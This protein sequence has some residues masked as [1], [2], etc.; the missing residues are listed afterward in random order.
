M[1]RLSFLVLASAFSTKVLAALVHPRNLDLPASPPGWKSIICLEDNRAFG[2]PLF[3]GAF[4]ADSALTIEKCI[5]FCDSQPV[6]YRYMGLTDGFECSCDNFFEYIFESVPGSCN[7]PCSGNPSEVGGCGGKA[8]L[9][10]LAS[11]YQR[12]NSTFV[13]PTM[14]S[15]VGLWNGLGCYNDSVSARALQVRVDAGQTTV[16]SCVAA[17]QTQGFSLAGV[18]FGRECWCGSQLQ[19]GSK[20]FGNSDGIQD[21]RLRQTPNAPFCNMA[22]QGNPSE[23]CGGPAL[24]NLYNFTGTYPIGASVVTTAGGWTSQGCYSDS[25]SSRTLERRVDVGSVTVESCVAACQSQSFTIAG[26]EYAQECWCGNEIKSPGVPISQ[27]ACHQVCIGDST[28][29]CGGPN[30]LQLYR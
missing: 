17:C 25:V 23:I 26:L 28:E 27:S 24:L 4:Y 15:S 9:Q 16:E 21:G 12:I 3:T 13:I 20:F 2:L 14:V 5:A 6:S 1:H 22:C 7:T 19:H 8:D 30:A 18:E 10:R 11:P 29:V